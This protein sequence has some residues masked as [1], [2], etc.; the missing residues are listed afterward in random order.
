MTTIERLARTSK[1][2]FD[3]RRQMD[4]LAWMVHPEG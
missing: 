1:L 4:L 3:L 2:S